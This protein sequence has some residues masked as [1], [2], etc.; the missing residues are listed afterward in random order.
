MAWIFTW[1][2]WPSVGN[3]WHLHRTLTKK[4]LSW[5]QWGP[6]SLHDRVIG[7][8]SWLSLGPPPPLLLPLHP[9]CL[10]RPHPC[11][12]PAGDL[13]PP[14]PH[15]SLLTE[16]WPHAKHCNRDLMINKAWIWLSFHKSLLLSGLWSEEVGLRDVWLPGCS[17]ILWLCCVV[18]FASESL[19][20]Y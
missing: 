14:C 6:R 9:S 5:G 19:V 2:V 1:C 11:H 12:L 16:T 8:T 15:I 7:E 13:S 3:W 18:I 10:S 20:D 17:C 4:L